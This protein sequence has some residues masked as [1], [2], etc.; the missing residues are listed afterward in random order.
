[1]D[2]KQ[3]LKLD[4]R[5][6]I[7]QRIDSMKSSLC[8]SKIKD[9]LSRFHYFG[10]PNQIPDLLIDKITSNIN[11]NSK[12]AIVNDFGLEVISKL[13][14]LGYSNLYILCT[15]ENDKLYSIIEYM[16]E[17]EFNFNR[18]RIVRLTNIDMNDK[19]DLVIANPPYE[20][21]NAVITETMKHCN[22]AIVLMPIAKYK[23]N[24][25][26][27]KIKSTITL[28]QKYDEFEDAFTNP[29]I[30]LLDNNENSKEYLNFIIEEVAD[31]KFKE[32]Y[33]FN[34][35]NSPTYIEHKYMIPKD[36]QVDECTFLANMWA[37]N[38]GFA[39][40]QDSLEVR[41][42]FSTHLDYKREWDQFCSENFS[43][44]KQTGMTSIKFKS[45]I[46]KENFQF[47]AYCSSPKD[48][49]MNKVFLGT[50]HNTSRPF[51]ECIP[52]IDWSKTD[53]IYND[54]YVLSQM[55]LKWNENKD[56]V[57]KI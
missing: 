56:G 24:N 53:V 2:S 30:A 15:E 52:S 44:V 45:K 37:P 1:M 18:D 26:Y 41:W 35:H 23:K 22:E 36:Y 6:S 5:Q 54:E 50:N 33:L 19:F 47:W 3:I 14:E 43:N 55:G 27:R 32:F 28:S 12:I 57:E 21:G 11:Y 16:I 38:G 10:Y 34:L 51:P 42:N 8:A 46:E 31:P 4:K 13:I 40:K 48:S 25:L 49:L 20:I 29:I 7:I 17:K 9:K 39:R